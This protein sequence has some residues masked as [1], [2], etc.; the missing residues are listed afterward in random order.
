M[1][2][3]SVHF[4]RWPRSLI[5]QDGR[6]TLPMTVDR[7]DLNQASLPSASVVWAN[8]K[9][10]IK[11]SCDVVAK[12]RPLTREE[13]V[14]GSILGNKRLRSSKTERKMIYDIYERYERLLNDGDCPMYDEMDC[15]SLLHKRIPATGW[16]GLLI[17]QVCSLG[18]EYSLSNIY[19][20]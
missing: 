9:T 11:G 2:R 17:H 15:I 14:D 20:L 3:L 4:F 12:G 19:C 7:A 10:F 5:S 16:P 6:G 8:I 13:F 1:L 18:I